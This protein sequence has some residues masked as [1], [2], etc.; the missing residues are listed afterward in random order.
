MIGKFSDIISNHK[1]N[2]AWGKVTSAVNAVGTFKRSKEDNQ[3]KWQDWS[4]AIKK[5]EIYRRNALKKTGGGQAVPDSNEMEVIVL[6]INS[7]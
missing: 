3:K 7:R 6:T 4:S 2:E 5:K 1:K